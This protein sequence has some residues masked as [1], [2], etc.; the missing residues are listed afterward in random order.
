MGPNSVRMSITGYGVNRCLRSDKS[1]V[2]RST[3]GAV[4][5][6]RAALRPRTDAGAVHCTTYAV[7]I[8]GPLR[9]STLGKREARAVIWG[10]EM[11]N[12]LDK[13]RGP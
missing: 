6:A 12:L 7:S 9:K 13:G 8:I 3:I 4:L 5:F 10:V 1:C 11:I 2:D